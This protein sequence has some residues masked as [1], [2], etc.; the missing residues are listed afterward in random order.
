MMQSTATTRQLSIKS[1]IELFETSAATPLKKLVPLQDRT[2]VVT[3]SKS[4]RSSEQ[5]WQDVKKN[6]RR[7]VAKDYEIND[8]KKEQSLKSQTS[9]GNF[10]QVRKQL[11]DSIEAPD[12]E[13]Y[14]GY[15][16]LQRVVS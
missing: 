11:F 10:V 9:Q 4:Q 16:W 15:Q 1:R 13:S 7:T 3:I 14:F 6:L 12:F 8:E 2:N 5:T